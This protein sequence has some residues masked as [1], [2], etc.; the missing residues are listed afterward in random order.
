M[1]PR[2]EDIVEPDEQRK[3]ASEA[4]SERPKTGH[5]TRSHSENAEEPKESRPSSSASSSSVNTSALLRSENDSQ[6]LS[7]EDV[8]D[9]EPPPL[10]VPT[11]LKSEHTVSGVNDVVDI[12]ADEPVSPEPIDPLVLRNAK[13]EYDPSKVIQLRESFQPIIT[14]AA[15]YGHFDVV[16]QLIEVS[17]I[18]MRK[19]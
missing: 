3:S 1:P 18:C 7:D 8:D 17:H 14:E 13:G 2:V 16:R 4:R 12:I 6:H 9:E 15:S 5:S 10:P 11:P 19:L